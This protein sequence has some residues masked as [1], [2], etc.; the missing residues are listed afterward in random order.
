MIP[1][2]DH[3]GV[4]ARRSSVAYL[5]AGSGRSDSPSPCD[6]ATPSVA[7]DDAVVGL[8]R[9]G[10]VTLSLATSCG[11]GAGLA[12]ERVAPAA[13]ARHAVDV[14]VVPR[15]IVVENIGGSS[16][17]LPSGRTSTFADGAPGSPPA[18]PYGGCTARSER[19]ISDVSGVRHRQARSTASP[20]RWRPGAAASRGRGRSAR[21]RSGTPISATSTGM[22]AAR[23]RRVREAV[24]AV[25]DGR[26][27]PGADDE[28]VEDE[29]ARPSGP[30]GA[31]DRERVAAL[32]GRR[33]AVGDQL[34]ERA[35]DRVEHPEAR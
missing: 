28:L 35:V 14:D 11:D 30:L 9:R 24:V 32:A 7:D 2:A 33:H 18:S 10:R 17:S 21:S 31:E 23:L 8:A 5:P 13:A 4:R 27:A 34:R 25:A 22:L 15:R 26:R 16:S 19:T 6:R 20:P 29:A 3:D 1:T 12:L